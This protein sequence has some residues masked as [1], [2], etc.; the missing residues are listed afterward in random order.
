MKSGYSVDKIWELSKIDKW[1]LRK[2]K[3][4][5]DLEDIVT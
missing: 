3:H 2:L 5:I 1:F 4:I